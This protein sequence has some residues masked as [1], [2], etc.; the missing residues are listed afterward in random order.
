MKRFALVI[1]TVGLAGCS[2]VESQSTRSYQQDIREPQEPLLRW[3]DTSLGIV[4]YGRY[5][6]SST[7][8]CVK[9]VP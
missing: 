5:Y 4:C 6:G 8:H 7:L 3:D 1:A 9:V 2:T